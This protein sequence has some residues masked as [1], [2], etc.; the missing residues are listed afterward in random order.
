MEDNWLF[1][2]RHIGSLPD[3]IEARVPGGTERGLAERSVSE[4]HKHWHTLEQDVWKYLKAKAGVLLTSDSEEIWKRQVSHFWYSSWVVGSRAELD[5]RSWFRNYDVFPDEPGEKCTVCGH[6][7]A[8]HGNGR[9]RKELREFWRTISGKLVPLDIREDGSERLCSICTV[10]RLFPRVAVQTIERDIPIAY[11]S[12]STMASLLWRAS[13]LEQSCKN[14]T[15]Q[16]AVSAFLKALKQCLP[17]SDYKIGAANFCPKLKD[18]AKGHPLGKA[19]E[20]F[21]EYDGDVFFPDGL[22]SLLANKPDVEQIRKDKLVTAQSDLLRAAKTAKAG[23]PSPFYALLLMD[24]DRMTKIIE[25]HVD[26]RKEISKA[27]GNFC[28]RTIDE[29]TK[30]GNSCGRVVYAGGDDL[31]VL[32]PLET[33]LATAK[34]L[35]EAYIKSFEE[36]AV[37][38]DTGLKPTISAAIIYAHMNTPLQAIVHRAHELLDRTAKE[39]AGRDAFAIE[40]WK[41]GGPALCFA[42]PWDSKDGENVN[43]VDRI[44]E[45]KDRLEKGQYSSSFLHHLKERCDFFMLSDGEPIVSEHDFLEFMVTE[46][47]KSRTRSLSVDEAKVIV[48]NLLEFS[49]RRGHNRDGT[50]WTRQYEGDPGLFLHFLWQKEVR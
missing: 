21:L 6:R 25:E 47:Q 12:T 32:L 19:A 18:L 10:K 1:T 8:L 48:R 35:R 37:F 22:T 33:A 49:R 4:W 28:K 23:E 38:K 31:L 39:Q 30:S 45:L 5:R 14:A 43:W 16:E 36:I 42:R 50:T 3:V 46:Y 13:V 27:L 7:E 44:S 24:G 17:E 20:D 2:N 34:A 41:R 26:K 40:V 15:L 29:I 11:P 9:T